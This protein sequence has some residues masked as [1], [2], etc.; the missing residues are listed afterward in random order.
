VGLRRLLEFGLPLSKT[1][2]PLV[3]VASR[4]YI[5]M[6]FASILFDTIAVI[7]HVIEIL[8]FIFA[9]TNCFDLPSMLNAYECKQ[10]KTQS[11]LSFTCHRP[12]FLIYTVNIHDAGRAVP[13]REHH[14]H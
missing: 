3:G 9:Q 11:F 10:L 1:S 14:N 4:A 6:H 12:P 2:R 5:Y 7:Y 8:V 13:S